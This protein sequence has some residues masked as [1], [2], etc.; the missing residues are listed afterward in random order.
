[1]TAFPEIAVIGAGAIGQ[2][3]VVDFT[4]RGYT[5]SALVEHNSAHVDALREVGQIRLSGHMGEVNVLMPPLALDADAAAKGRVILVATTVDAH[6]AVAHALAP[7]LMNEHLVLLANGYVNG[8]QR[9]AAALEAGGCTTR[10]AVLELN[11]TPF[12]VCSPEPG[13]VHVT[14]RKR[15]MELSSFEDGLAR[16]HHELLA[17]I[18]PGIEVCDNA[19]ASSLN[20]QN[21][22]AHVPSYLLNA[23]EA[24]CSEPVAPD[25]TRGGAF[26]LEDYSSEEVLQL[27]TALDHERMQVM[28]ALGLGDY[29]I[30]RTEFSLKSY[31]PGAREAVSPRMGRTFSR[32]FVTEDVPYGLIPI[33]KLARQAGVNT[34]VISGIITLIGAL[35]SYNWRR[36]CKGAD[37]GD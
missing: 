8:S 14:A 31:G 10:P 37:D 21:P 1:M 26:Y 24:R 29:A 11:T 9:F 7:A 12:L 2:T 36:R 28:R 25:A 13:R 3:F 30:A 15:W 23:A 33:E 22:V 5:V 19:L 4:R 17:G 34:P 35:E 18:V 16:K 32:R 20:N 6:E 27:R